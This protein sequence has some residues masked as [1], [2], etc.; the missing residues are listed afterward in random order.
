MT[1]FPNDA[2]NLRLLLQAIVYCTFKQTSSI[3]C[4]QL[5]DILLWIYINLHIHYTMFLVKLYEVT[6]T[7]FYVTET[8]AL[9]FSGLDANVSP[10]CFTGVENIY[11]NRQY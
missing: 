10:E 2:I 7:V 8:G 9:S 6:S 11:L 1:C 5:D 4:E 3:I